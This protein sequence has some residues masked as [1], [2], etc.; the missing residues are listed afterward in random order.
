MPSL[1]PSLLF[2]AGLS[3]GLG[4]AVLFPR[5]SAPVPSSSVVLPPPPPEGGK[6][7][8]TL[9]TPTGGITLQGG[10]PGK[11]FVCSVSPRAHG[12]VLYRILSSGQRTLQRLT[13][14]CGTLPG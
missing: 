5:K 13:G 9:A 10:F 7:I 4:T 14:V 3:L 2:A 6:Q 11:F 12:Q 8:A 1:G